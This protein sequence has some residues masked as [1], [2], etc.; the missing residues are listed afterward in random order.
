MARA[1]MAFALEKLGQHYVTRLVDFLYA[2]DL[3][4][5]VQGYLIELG[6]PDREG[7]AA[8]AAGAR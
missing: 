8:A 6:A 3:S 1:A 7:S 4:L 2:D 5:Q